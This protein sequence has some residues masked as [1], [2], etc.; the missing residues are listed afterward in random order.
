MMFWKSL[1]VGESSGKASK[2]VAVYTPGNMAALD[3]KAGGAMGAVARA[4]LVRGTGAE[5]MYSIG[6]CH[7]GF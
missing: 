2:G 7:P 6:P 5:Y 4:R 1:S 3:A